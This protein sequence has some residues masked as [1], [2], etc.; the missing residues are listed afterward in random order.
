MSNIDVNSFTYFNYTKSDE[1]RDNL[2]FFDALPFQLHLKKIISDFQH[3]SSPT[4]ELE[5]MAR[6]HFF[7]I[8]TRDT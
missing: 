3:D 6:L 8:R 7:V 5:G 4:I 1:L 2:G